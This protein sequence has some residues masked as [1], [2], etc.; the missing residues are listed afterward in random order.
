MKQEKPCTC[1]MAIY[2]SFQ[3]KLKW[4]IVP[5][6]SS[7]CLLFPGSFETNF[8]E[9]IQWAEDINDGL[10]GYNQ[11]LRGHEKFDLPQTW[12]SS[13]KTTS[14]RSRCSGCLH[15]KKIM[16]YNLHFYV[17]GL[18]YLENDDK[19]VQTELLFCLATNCSGNV[20]SSLKGLRPLAGTRWSGSNKRSSVRSS[21]IIKSKKRKKA[22]LKTSKNK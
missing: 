9:Y 20:T 6:D 18:F 1:R 11:N 2:V 5:T 7:Q 4:P 10:R 13:K 16:Q 21:V 19:V 12:Y 17:K 22:A 3:I 8:W 14:T 15:P